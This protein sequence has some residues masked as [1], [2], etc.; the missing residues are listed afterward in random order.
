MRPE[1]P[2]RSTLRSRAVSSIFWAGTMTPRSKH[3]I[4]VALQHD[5]DDVLADVV[6][7]ALHRGHED[8]A[9]GRTPL[10]LL[11][12]DIGREDRPPPSS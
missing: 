9:L 10:L 11:R 1:R 8:A 6:H 4:V 2:I 7:V 12:F 3:L 5:A